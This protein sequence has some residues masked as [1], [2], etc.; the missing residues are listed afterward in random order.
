MVDHEI[1]QALERA[2]NTCSE[3]SEQAG[4]EEDGEPQD[5]ALSP[6]IAS[7]FVCSQLYIGM[8]IGN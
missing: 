7:T 8:V 6:A 3:L 2:W 4:A 5:R 1:C